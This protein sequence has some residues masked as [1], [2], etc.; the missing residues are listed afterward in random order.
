LESI[1]SQLLGEPR[2]CDN[3]CD[4][5][6]Y[7]RKELS[8]RKVYVILFEESER[9]RDVDLYY[10]QVFTRLQELTGCNIS[11]IWE[12]RI[13]WPRFLPCRGL[14]D[15]IIIHFPQYSKSELTK[16]LT[17]ELPGDQSAEFKKDYI[18]MVLSIFHLVTRSLIELSH[19]CCLNYGDYCL[20]VIKG[21]CSPEDS[22][23]LWFNVEKQLYKCLSTVH[24]REVASQQILDIHRQNELE[25]QAKSDSGTGTTNTLG[26]GARLKVELPYYSKFLL[27]SAYL[28]SYNPQKTDKRFF[29]KHHGKQRK[30]S[31]SIMA[32]DKFNSQLTGPKAFPLER[33]LAIFYNIIEERVNPT[34]NIYSQLSS[35]V[36]LQL[37]VSVGLEQIDQPKYKCNVSLEFIKDIS[38]SVQFDV[39]K[40]LYNV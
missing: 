4:F 24:L 29:V 11:V 35:L 17:V 14:P 38:K 30:T 2:K 22:Q 19:I 37:M 20:P 16:L 7:L 12:S 21:E 28:A 9:F 6:S 3:I 1:L 39:C 25:Q 5:V 32:K 31:S 8:P 10:T 34:A 33:L 27:V 18:T 26:P 40:Y 13:G 15:P 36:K 23:K